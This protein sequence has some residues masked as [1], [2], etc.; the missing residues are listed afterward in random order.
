MQTRARTSACSL[1]RWAVHGL[2]ALALLAFGCASPR[3]PATTSPSPE[4]TWV[5]TYRYALRESR[6]R[7]TYVLQLEPGGVARMRSESWHLRVG[8]T[9]PKAEVGTWSVR[10]HMLQLRLQDQPDGD[11]FSTSIGLR[12]PAGQIGLFFWISSSMTLWADGNWRKPPEADDDITVA[13]PGDEPA[14]PSSEAWWR[15]AYGKLNLMLA[16]DPVAWLSRVPTGL[17]VANED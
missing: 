1:G 12:N 14:D 4:S 2:L 10:D 17:D 8:D 7:E 11:E 9:D 5:G 16:R 6:S 13:D 15:W 3:P